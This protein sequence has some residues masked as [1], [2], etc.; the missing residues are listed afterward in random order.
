MT[1]IS[2]I[3]LFFVIRLWF[4]KSSDSHY[5]IG[6][7]TNTIEANLAI[8]TATMPTLWPL[9]RVWFPN[10]FESMGINRPYLCP[11]IECVPCASTTQL[12][13]TGSSDATPHIHPSA[14]PLRAKIIWLQRPHSNPSFVRP[15]IATPVS[16]DHDSGLGG[17][18][19]VAL[20][21]MRAPKRGA[22]IPVLRG[23]AGRTESPP[24]GRRQ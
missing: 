7:A 21:D 9:A 5:S 2:G 4:M 17:N 3:R 12:R 13:M 8:V 10:M 11:D 18:E 24:C 22:A 6:Y 1:C 20:S 19:A 14:P 16:D 15:P 23:T